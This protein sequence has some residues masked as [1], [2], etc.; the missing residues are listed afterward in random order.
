M[1][2]QQSL[3]G[4]T[5][6]GLVQRLSLPHAAGYVARCARCR[7]VIARANASTSATRTAAF[8]LAAL[9]LYPAAVALPVIEISKLGHTHVA[10]VWSGAIELMSD[11]QVAIGLLVFVCSIVVPLLKIGALLLLSAGRLR[12]H[13]GAA[14]YRFMEWIGRWGMLDVLLVAVL[15]AA[16]KLGNWADVHP[17]PGIAAFAGVVVLSLL[18]SASF[19]PATLWEPERE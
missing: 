5:R 10:T 12:P 11:G 4:C 17:G 19:D 8:S 15:V 18:A 13:H 6:C 1:S 2:D 9:L 3:T 14:A 16:V 7:G